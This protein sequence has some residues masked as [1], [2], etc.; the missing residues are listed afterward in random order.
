MSGKNLTD[1]VHHLRL[2]L[3]V[4][5]KH[6]LFA[7]QS[8][9]VFACKEVEYLGHLISGDGVRIDPRKIAAMQQ[10]P[11]PKDV[12]A[13]RGFLGLT[14]YYRKFVKRYGQI[15]APLTT[16]LRKDSFAWTSE[17]SHTFQLLKDAMS[18]PPVLALPDFSKS[19]VVECDASGLGVGA[20]LMQNQRP[21]AYHSQA[22]KENLVAD[23]LSRREAVEEGVVEGDNVGTL[24]IISF[25]TPTWMDD[26]KTSY[27]SDSAAQ[28]II[29]A[30]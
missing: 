5:V 29:L 14:G 10:W 3:E 15:A 30:I 24:Y 22:L 19:F 9:C 4:L 12:M 23:A 11:I 2:V 28:K 16:L 18:N 1:H 21:I 13:L 6:Q 26:L 8:K 25:L 20:V 27:T 17:A 7:K